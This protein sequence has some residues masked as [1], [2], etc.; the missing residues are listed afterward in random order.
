MEYSENKRDRIDV[1]VILHICYTMFHDMR[2]TY[3]ANF[4]YINIL[5]SCTF[6]LAVHSSTWKWK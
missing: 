5:W 6:F 2:L 1:R 4:Q 3:I